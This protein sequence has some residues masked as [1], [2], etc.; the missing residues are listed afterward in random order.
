M[1]NLLTEEKGK[2]EAVAQ[3]EN[4]ITKVENRTV[5]LK[6]KYARYIVWVYK[7][8]GLSMWRFILDADS[9]NQAIKRYRYLEYSA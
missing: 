5:D 9:F 1:N 8:R 2:G 6:E 7:N 4:E 3:T